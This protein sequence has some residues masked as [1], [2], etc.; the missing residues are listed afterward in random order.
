[1]SEEEK[2]GAPQGSFEHATKYRLLV[3]Q[4]SMRSC[5]ASQR[6]AIRRAADVVKADAI[7]RLDGVGVAAVLTAN[8]A[9]DVG[10]ALVAQLNAHLNQLG[11]ARINRSK[12]VVRQDAL[13][14]VLM[15]ELSLNVVAGEAERGLGKVVGAEAE[16]GGPRSS[17]RDHDPACFRCS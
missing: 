5:K 2:E 16:E 4:C 17:A 12:R 15:D 3:C 7:E 6:H 11:N 9:N 1:M 8:T 13:C 10:V 14:E